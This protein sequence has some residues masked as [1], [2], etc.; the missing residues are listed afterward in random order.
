VR[1]LKELG[2]SSVRHYR[3]GLADWKENAL[4]IERDEPPALLPRPVR[5]TEN[6]RR[7]WAGA[8]L[9]AIDRRSTAELFLFWITMVILCGVT[10]WLVGTSKEHGLAS[11]GVPLDMT[12]RGLLTAIY[13]SFVTATST[14]YGDVVPLGLIRALAIAEAIAGLLIFGAVVSKFVSRRQDELVSEIHRVTFEDRLDRVQTNL[15]LVLSELQAISSL[16]GDGQAP[17][18]RVAVRLESASMVF[19]GELRAI[20]DLLYRPQHAPEPE[21]LEAILAGL[22]ASFRE[23]A[24][25]LACLPSGYRRAPALDTALGTMA[26]LANE[27]CGECVPRA[28]APALTVWMDRVQELA[29]RISRG[30]SRPEVTP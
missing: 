9:D 7:E 18:P 19:V 27:I 29:R 4:P 21:I 30:S 12:W 20:H 25:L 13:F 10:Y 8:L 24:E 14:G 28:Y 23:L 1:L 17:S 3:G 5:R 26:R 11:A 2:Y 6:S 16:C 22:A 15:H